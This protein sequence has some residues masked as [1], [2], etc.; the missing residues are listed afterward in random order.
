MIGSDVK[1]VRMIALFLLG[2]TLFNPPLLEVFDIGG[3]KVVAGIPVLFFYLFVAWAALIGLMALVVERR[4]DR[5][6][7]RNALT[8]RPGSKS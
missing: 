8:G 4:G 5:P 6:E 2:L 7:Q 3:D 1:N